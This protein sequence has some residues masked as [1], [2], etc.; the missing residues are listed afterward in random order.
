MLKPHNVIRRDAQR[1]IWPAKKPLKN[2]QLWDRN[3]RMVRALTT[4]CLVEQWLE[5]EEGKDMY[6]S[7]PHVYKHGEVEIRFLPH[8]DFY[9]VGG[10][11]LPIPEEVR[12]HAILQAIQ[13]VAQLIKL[14]YKQAETK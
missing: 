4:M 9:V 2:V 1:I 12:P 7:M 10:I 3:V 11:S 14:G 6:M 13:A 8:W 5:G